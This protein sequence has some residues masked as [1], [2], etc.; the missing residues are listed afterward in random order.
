MIKNGSPWFDFYTYDPYPGSFTE[1]E[2][3]NPVRLE[4]D[5]K[6]KIHRGDDFVLSYRNFIFEM[7]NESLENQKQ[8]ALQLFDKGYVNRIVFSGSK[9]Y[10]MR[11]SVTESCEP[12][13]KE[14]YE[15]LR[16]IIKKEWLELEGDDPAVKDPS[17]LTR[18]PNGTRYAKDEH[19]LYIFTIPGQ[20]KI[21]CRQTLLVPPQNTEIEV[22]DWKQRWAEEKYRRFCEAEDLRAK[23]KKYAGTFNID[24]FVIRTKNDNVR[25]LYYNNFGE[26]ERNNGTMS[27]IGTLKKAGA[28]REVIENLVLRVDLGSEIERRNFLRRI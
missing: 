4:R 11:V 18:Y 12:K 8:K 20:H 2:T 3:I 21:V 7:D 23:A 25:K 22:D 27:A 5:E 10:H 6:G 26:G 13:T 24:K 15:F 28:P 19:G 17:R 9:S 14:E 1:F 16:N